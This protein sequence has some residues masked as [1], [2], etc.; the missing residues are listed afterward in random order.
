MTENTV[1]KELFEVVKNA[2]PLD[3]IAYARKIQVLVALYH[4]GG[5]QED[6]LAA[7][8]AKDYFVNHFI[9]NK[10][11]GV[12]QSVDANGERDNASKKTLA[13][14]YAIAAL[15]DFVKVVKDESVLAIAQNIYHTIETNVWCE[16]CGSY[17]KGRERDWSVP[18]STCAAKGGCK[19][20]QNAVY[21]AYCKLYS[22]WP[23]AI[24]KCSIIKAFGAIV[25]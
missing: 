9:D 15:A 8:N 20:V 1:T 5:R 2:N 21:D 6:L 19:S 22:V 16:E 18:E 13:Q 10:F 14:A 23:H 17:V 25:K 11:G 4:E 12:Y 3:S 24:L 7:I